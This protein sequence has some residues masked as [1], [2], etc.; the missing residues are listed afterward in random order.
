MWACTKVQYAYSV[1]LAVPDCCAQANLDHD[2]CSKDAEIIAAWSIS[3]C[4]KK[5]APE[6]TKNHTQKT[7]VRYAVATYTNNA[8]RNKMRGLA[9]NTLTGSRWPTSPL[10][11]TVADT[12]CSAR[13]YF[14]HTVEPS[15]PYFMR[16]SHVAM[17]PAA[18][19]M[20]MLEGS[21]SCSHSRTC[22]CGLH[23]TPHPHDQ[24]GRTVMQKKSKNINQPMKKSQTPPVQPPPVP[25][26]R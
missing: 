16:M 15:C 12:Q 3:W 9:G 5:G 26:S 4:S 1:T 11:D 17:C 10:D 23:D 7:H 24:Q 2:A 18:A 13:M 25:R 8:T 20:R 6:H 21:G 22:A 14:C 19:G